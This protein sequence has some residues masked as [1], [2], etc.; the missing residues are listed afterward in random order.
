MAVSVKRAEAVIFVCMAPQYGRARALASVRYPRITLEL[1]D[2]A[3]K[4]DLC[5]TRTVT[6]R[7]TTMTDHGRR[8]FAW[9]VRHAAIIGFVLGLL[10]QAMQHV[11]PE[12]YCDVCKQIA[13]ICTGDLP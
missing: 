10:C 13:H 7:A 4:Q 1:P 5:H 12:R 11:L 9:A 3:H 6:E 8:G 2:G